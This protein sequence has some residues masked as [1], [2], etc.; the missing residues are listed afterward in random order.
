VQ[1]EV[2]PQLHC[3]AHAVRESSF[4]TPT[5]SGIRKAKTPTE[6]GMLVKRQGLGHDVSDLIVGW[7]IIDLAVS[8]FNEFSNIVVADVDMLR[9][10]VMCRIYGKEDSSLVVNAD[11]GRVAHVFAKFFKE[12]AKVSHESASV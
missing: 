12:I 11:R 3:S 6:C 8:L 9:P 7:D 1:S 10:F 4:D 2:F 5:C